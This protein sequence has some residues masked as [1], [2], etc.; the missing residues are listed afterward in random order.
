[1]IEALR[2]FAAL[3]AV[4][5]F[6]AP[7]A[8][9]LRI[10]INRATLEPLPIA[11]S[12]FDAEAAEGAQILVHAAAD[13]PFVAV[14]AVERFRRS[15]AEEMLAGG[16]LAV[17]RGV[18]DFGFPAGDAAEF[19]LGVS[20]L[21]AE[22]FLHGAGGGEVDANFEAQA[23]EFFEVFALEVDGHRPELGRET[24]FESVLRDAGAACF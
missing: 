9:Q 11:I 3:V 6:V 10:D 24:V 19:P 18:E 1:M 20:D 14:E 13:L 4:L 2:L 23:L 15:F 22:R 16:D 5:A 17:E 21:V 12:D 8:A 7:A